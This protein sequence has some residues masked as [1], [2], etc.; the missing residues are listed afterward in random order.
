[1]K[2]HHFIESS[3]FLILQEKKHNELKI[4]LNQLQR[5]A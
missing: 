1:M 2:N 5:Q 3:F 4:F